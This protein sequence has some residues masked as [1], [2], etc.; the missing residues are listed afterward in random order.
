MI[1]KEID[2][3]ALPIT[4]RMIKK[5]IDFFVSPN[6]EIIDL[7][8]QV[9]EFITILKNLVKRAFIQDKSNYT[10]KIHD[11]GIYS[12]IKDVV[13]SDRNDHD[14]VKDNMKLWYTFIRKNPH[15]IIKYLE[16]DLSY[17]NFHANYIDK[18]NIYDPY[19]ALNFTHDRIDCSKIIN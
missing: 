7:S 2:F 18:T 6:T 8:Y 12:D 16:K 5:E 4:E 14:F 15:I 3:F 19:V 10:L 17:L 13:F 1:K 11:Y 9:K